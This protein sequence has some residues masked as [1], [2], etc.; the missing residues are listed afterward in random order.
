[1]GDAL[2]TADDRVDEL[3]K[4]LAAQGIPCLVACGAADE[5]W[6]P[7]VQEEMAS[8]LS[9]RFVLLPDAGHS[10]AIENPVSTVAALA[11]H[12]R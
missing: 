5:A 3:A 11:A 8:R 7:A 9:A 12:W 1:M 10:P 4:T 2:L 6:P